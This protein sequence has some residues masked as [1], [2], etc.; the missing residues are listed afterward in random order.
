MLLEYNDLHGEY[1]IKCPM[2]TRLKFQY[3]IIKNLWEIYLSLYALMYGTKIC[4]WFKLLKFDYYQ[5]F[6]KEFYWPTCK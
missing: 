1:L 3:F 5:T 4:V 6:R 2:H